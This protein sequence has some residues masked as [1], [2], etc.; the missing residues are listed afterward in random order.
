MVTG[1]IPVEKLNRPQLKLKRGSSPL[2]MDETLVA[3]PRDVRAL[4]SGAAPT[5]SGYMYEFEFTDASDDRGVFHIP[6]KKVF[7]GSYSCAL[8]YRT[9]THIHL[10]LLTNDTVPASDQPIVTSGRVERSYVPFNT[11]EIYVL[12]FA[13]NPTV[14]TTLIPAS[15]AELKSLSRSRKISGE[16]LRTVVLLSF[17]VLIY[18]FWFML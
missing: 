1:T 15:D 7:D 3:R 4:A 2:R 16:M 9:P 6:L 5:A 10:N 17:S 12:S 8:I 14:M 13:P 11:A 18:S